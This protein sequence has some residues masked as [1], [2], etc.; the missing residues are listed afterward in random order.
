MSAPPASHYPDNP[1]VAPNG[2]IRKRV[3]VCCDGTWQDGI[4][5]DARWKYTNI[6][7][8]SRALNHED[9]RTNPATPQV[10]F[11]QTGIGSEHNFYSEYIQGATGA[12]LGEKVQEAYGFISQN[13]QPGDEIFLFGFSR[14]A[15]TARM[16]AAFIG[17]IGVLDR[18]D[19]DH[20]ADIFVAYQ[21]RGKTKDKAAVAA[22]DVKLAPWTAHDSP[23]KKRADSDQDSFSIKV[24]GVFDTVG[25]LGLPEELTGKSHQMNLIFGFPDHTLGEHVENAFHAL[26]LNETRAD[27]NCAKFE[28]TPG[29]R[30]KGQVLKQCWFTGSHSDIGG[31]WHDHDLADLTLTWMIAQVEPF[32]SLDN[33]YLWSLP[34]PCYPW[35]EQ[36]PHDPRTGIFTLANKI[37]RTLPTSTDDVTHEKIHPSVLAQKNL[38]PQLQTNLK[39]DPDLVA[40]LLPVEQKV[41]DN[42]AYVPGKYPPQDN[43]TEEVAKNKPDDAMHKSLLK[44]M[45]ETGSSMGQQALHGLTHTKIMENASGSAVTEKNAFGKYL[46]E[47]PFGAHIKAWM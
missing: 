17:A 44:T 32:L 31:G 42:W 29:G 37:T 16:I 39:Q 14:G 38:I 3:I 35:G 10:V 36:P 1:P 46:D 2:R 26:A 22:L 43:K 40:T 9:T 24:V 23:G 28:Q 18:Q 34:Q 30:A 12:S 19:M 15:Y 27:F 25:S 6:L 47:S 13:Y 41:K 11:Y 21:K 5:V 20:F 8:L 33:K 4:V 45:V 7:R